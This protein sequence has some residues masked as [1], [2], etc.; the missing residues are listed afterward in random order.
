MS[1]SLSFWLRGILRVV[2]L[3]CFSC[4]LM[5]L[6]QINRLLAAI[7]ATVGGTISVPELCWKILPVT[8]PLIPAIAGI[9]GA[10]LALL[11]VKPT[12]HDLDKPW[13]AN[14]MWAAK[15]IRLSNR[16]VFWSIALCFFFYIGI[17]VP[18]SIGTEKTA[19]LVVSGVLG[20]VLLLMARVF[21]R[22][23][24]WNT[25]ELRM[26]AVPGV[27]GGPFSGVAIVQ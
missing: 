13:L 16:G 21:W 11:H 25:A 1:P 23:R 15:H 2:Q 19:F 5:G 4:M 9:V 20:L 12:T 18:L 7:A 10:Y 8:G 17:L 22:N 27:I 3:L 24:K 6:S 26:A 14:P